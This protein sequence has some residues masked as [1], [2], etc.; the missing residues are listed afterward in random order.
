[1]SMDGSSGEGL[2]SGYL[3]PMRVHASPARSNF[4]GQASPRSGNT[5]PTKTQF[6]SAAANQYGHD[7]L[8]AAPPGN[9]WKRIHDAVTNVEKLEGPNYPSWRYWFHR[10][11]TSAGKVWGH[12]N[13]SCPRPERNPNLKPE[14]VDP[15]VE[16]WDMD[17]AA[18]YCALLSSLEFAIV[19]PQVQACTTAKEVWDRLSLLYTECPTPET[20]AADLMREL[21]QAV[22]YEGE[23]LKAHLWRLKRIVQELQSSPYP[24]PDPLAVWFIYDSMPSSFASHVAALRK[25]TQMS[26]A[27]VCMALHAIGQ[28]LLGSQCFGKQ[29]R[30]LYEAHQRSAALPFDL[31][32][33]KYRGNGLRG[34]GALYARA[35]RT[36]GACLATGHAPFTAEC[37]QTDVRLGLWG[38]RVD[39]VWADQLG[40]PAAASPNGMMPGGRT[41]PSGRFTPNGQLPPGGQPNNGG[42]VSFGAMSS[43][44]SGTGNGIGGNALGIVSSRPSGAQLDNWR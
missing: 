39:P 18:I 10:K 35:R 30:S 34:D 23:D 13:G 22:Y 11:V 38:L 25:E 6:E 41:T 14:E 1:M 15:E 19:Y 20:R 43:G 21:S 12:I 5:S 16:R 33:Y 31:R 42:Q 28:Q 44:P 3:S 32:H 36:C 9:I 26:V 7:A 37:P 40:Q 27:A 8:N 4:G 2:A 29:G 17:E 24:I